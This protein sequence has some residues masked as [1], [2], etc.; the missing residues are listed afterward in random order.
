MLKFC[1]GSRTDDEMAGNLRVLQNVARL[2]LDNFGREVKLSRYFDSIIGIHPSDATYTS[3]CLMGLDILYHRG[4]LHAFPF[5]EQAR[6]FMM[7]YQKLHGLSILDVSLGVSLSDSAGHRR[8]R[9]TFYNV[10]D[11]V[12]N[13]NL[14]KRF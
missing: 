10:S 13:S 5:A 14:L 2:T 9:G 8:D 6:K 12:R 1:S 7:E 4:T 11:L 3:D